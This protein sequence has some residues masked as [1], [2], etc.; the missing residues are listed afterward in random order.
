MNQVPC[1]VFSKHDR[2]FLFPVICPFEARDGLFSD[3]LPVFLQ[4]A[5]DSTSGYYRPYSNITNGSLCLYLSSCY[6]GDFSGMIFN[7]A[8]RLSIG[9]TRINLGNSNDDLPVAKAR[10]LSWVQDT[11]MPG[12]GM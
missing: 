7:L 3:E 12:E 5:V 1:V 9:Y 8:D 6:A 11:W 4:P 2:K 10:N